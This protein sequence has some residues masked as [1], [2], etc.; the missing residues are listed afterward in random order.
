[1]RIRKHLFALAIF[2]FFFVNNTYSQL[3]E[4]KEI[5]TNLQWLEDILDSAL[6]DLIDRNVLKMGELVHL[7][8]FS[9]DTVFND[10]QNS[11]IRRKLLSKYNV[12]VVSANGG[13]IRFDKKIIIRWVNWQVSF[14][15]EKKKFWHKTKY[16]RNIS[17]DFFVEIEDSKTKEMVYT[18]R[19]QKS[20]LDLIFHLN[21]VQ[22][23]NLLFTMG[24]VIEKKGIIPG[25]V[26][27]VFLF[28]ISGTVVY[29]F[30]S[31]RSE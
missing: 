29:L 23:E 15:V 25:W 26:E 30:Y 19:Y 8:V 2:S 18:N 7:E 22:T 28:A 20:Q 10:F 6:T 5:T 3:L 1:V 17:A 4:D 9:I 14:E 13:S 16:Q 31:I 12:T 11:Y 21:A 24:H 27:P